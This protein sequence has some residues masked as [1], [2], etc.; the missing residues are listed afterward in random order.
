MMN[1]MSAGVDM[2]YPHE[3]QIEPQQNKRAQHR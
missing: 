3:V 1:Q 2:A